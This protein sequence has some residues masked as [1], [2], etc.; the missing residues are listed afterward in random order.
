M[1]IYGAR[2]YRRQQA[3]DSMPTIKQIIEKPDTFEGKC[4]AWFIQ[5]LII[6]SIVSFSIETLPDLSEG[7][8]QVLRITE[9]VC[10]LI[11]TVEYLA[12]LIVATEKRKFIFSF[13]GIID[14][15]AIA[16]FYLSVGLD[17]R[18]LRALRLFRILRILKFARY[19]KA[20]T[21]LGKA[22][23]IAREELVLFL[24]AAVIIVYL[25]AVGIYYFENAVQPEAFSSIFHSLWW[26]VATLTTVGYGDVVPVTAGGRTFT[27]LVLLVGL[28]VISMPA[29][30]VAS[31]L[32]K[33]REQE[34]SQDSGNH[35]EK[36]EGLPPGEQ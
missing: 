15:I 12:R 14:F 25:A 7:T 35:P 28:G 22:F 18:S 34:A 13:Y 26:A 11:F 30:I 24:A 29:A 4:F 3:Q 31:A 1:Y 19:N 8:R 16:P 17:L 2:P 9:I 21:R 32:S 27:F 5:T 10:V 6:I 33:V 36:P 23:R 20:I